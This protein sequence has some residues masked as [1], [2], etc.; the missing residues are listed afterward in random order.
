MIKEERYQPRKTITEDDSPFKRMSGMHFRRSFTLMSATSKKT[1][2]HDRGNP[3]S[4]EE[5]SK[6]EE[7]ESDDSFKTEFEESEEKESET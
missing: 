7:D 2:V 1:S 3:A 5:E 6:S 4:L